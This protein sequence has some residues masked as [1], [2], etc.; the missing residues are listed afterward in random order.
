MSAMRENAGRGEA[1][2]DSIASRFEARA[3][4]RP[5]AVA[6]RSEGRDVTYGE[7]DALAEGVARALASRGLE[8]GDRVGVLVRDFHSLPVALLGI[9]KAGCVYVPVDPTFPPA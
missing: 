3:I 9:L 8:S 2:S 5:T 4:E 7:L 6:V 1:A